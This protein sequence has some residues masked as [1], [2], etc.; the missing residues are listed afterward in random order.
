[1]E[2]LLFILFQIV[3]RIKFLTLIDRRRRMQFS[4][5][6]RNAVKRVYEITY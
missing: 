1:M 5:F 3:L 4:L 6:Y 2:E